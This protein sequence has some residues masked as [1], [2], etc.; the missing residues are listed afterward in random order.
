MPSAK[1]CKGMSLPPWIPAA[2]TYDAW[3]KVLSVTDANGNANTSSTFIGNVNPIRYRGYYYDKET[4]WYYLNSRYYDPQVRRFINADEMIHN[5]YEFFG[6][7][8]F[9]YGL[10]NPVNICDMSGQSPTYI[11][12]QYDDM[13]VEYLGANTKMKDIS[14]GLLGNIA[15]NGC[16]VIAVYNVLLNMD[17][18]TTFTSVKDGLEEI[19]GPFMFGK[20]GTKPG[21]IIAYLQSMGVHGWAQYTLDG[22]LNGYYWGLKLE[23]SDAVIILYKI[24]TLS[25]H[26][27]AGLR[28]SGSGINSK[29]RFFNAFGDLTS[30]NT[31]TFFDA[32]AYIEEQGNEIKFVT[33]IKY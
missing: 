8:Q 10:N 11:A 13:V 29:Y 9:A 3:G 22:S 4:G 15:D 19:G 5:G 17:I 1:T 18:D 12:D 28:I 20:M 16:G 31:H 33:G 21:A 24:S 26:Y 23:Q 27:I 7:N 6:C 14:W 2:N 30:Q 25:Y 32:I